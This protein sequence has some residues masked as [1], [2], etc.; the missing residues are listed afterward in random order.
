ME[1]SMVTF[2]DRMLGRYPEPTTKQ[3]RR[4]VRVYCRTINA[5]FKGTRRRTRR[6]VA[7]TRKLALKKG[8]R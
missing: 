5:G 4:D 8:S 6:L 3:E 1:T 2:E 7:L